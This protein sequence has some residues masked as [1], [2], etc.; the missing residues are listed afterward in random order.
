M[1]QK[2]LFLGVWDESRG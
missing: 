2:Y 1:L